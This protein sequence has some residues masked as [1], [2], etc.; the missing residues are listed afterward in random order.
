VNALGPTPFGEI[1]SAVSSLTPRSP[2]EFPC[3]GE[4]Q[5]REIDREHVEALLGEPDA[6]SSLAIGDRKHA[7]GFRQQRRVLAQKAVGSVP[8]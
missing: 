3:L 5:R 7:S 2:R 4:R 1:A 8:K 6:V